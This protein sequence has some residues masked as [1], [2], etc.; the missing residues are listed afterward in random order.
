M[1]D[2]GFSILFLDNS[3]DPKLQHQR[4]NNL[5][6]ERRSLAITRG[7]VRDTADRC[8]SQ[9]EPSTFGGSEMSCS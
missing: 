4:Q 2:S 9:R 3:I 5:F 8:L 7:Q 6:I 1:C